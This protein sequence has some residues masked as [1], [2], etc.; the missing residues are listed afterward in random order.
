MIQRNSGTISAQQTLFGTRTVP[1]PEGEGSHVVSVGKRRDGGTRYWC[2]KHKADATAK[3]GKPATACRT[4]HFPPIAEEDLLPIDFAKHPGGAAMG[5]AV[6]PV[7]D[8][9]TR[10]RD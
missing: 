6:P 8:T 7:Q 2:L 9:A 5:V 10:P 3:Y 1:V 4:A